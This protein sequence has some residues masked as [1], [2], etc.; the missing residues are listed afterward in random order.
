MLPDISPPLTSVYPLENP[1]HLLSVPFSFLHYIL[2][3]T[4]FLLSP[5]PPLLLF[6]MLVLQNQLSTNSLIPSLFCRWLWSF[7]PEVSSTRC[8]PSA[9]GLLWGQ[10]PYR[11]GLPGALPCPEHCALY[12]VE[13]PQWAR[14]GMPPRLPCS[15]GICQQQRHTLANLHGKDTIWK[16]IGCLPDSPRRLQNTVLDSGCVRGQ[17]GARATP[18]GSLVRTTCHHGWPHVSVTA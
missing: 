12:M 8:F 2:F 16:D 13:F 3:F 14:E 11:F 10:G 1:I 18:R 17:P 15:H 5:P 7:V 4:P 9:C 6:Q